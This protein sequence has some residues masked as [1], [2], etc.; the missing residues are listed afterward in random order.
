MF[1]WHYFFSHY[2]ANKCLAMAFRVLDL[3]VIQQGN[4]SRYL[5]NVITIEMGH[6][7]MGEET[8][9]KAKSELMMKPGRMEVTS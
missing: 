7:G 1:C 8:G 5:R 3:P 9:S 2:L 6:V 4:S